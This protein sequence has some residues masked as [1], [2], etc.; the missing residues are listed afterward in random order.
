MTVNQYL[1][2]A[3]IETVWRL[4]AGIIPVSALGGARPL[5]GVRLVL[6]RV[7]KPHP[8]PAGAGAIGNYDVGIGLPAVARNGAGRFAITYSVPG[9]SSPVAVRLYDT[10]RRYVPRRFRLPVPAEATVV[11]AEQAAEQPPWPPIPSRAFRPVLYPGANWGTQ[12]GATA[13]RGRV[14]RADGSAA[15]WARVSA[16]DADHRYPAGWAHGDDRGEFLLVLTPSDAGLFTPGSALAHVTLTI[17]ARPV[18]VTIDSPAQSQA[19]PLWDLE[20]E[21]LPPPGAADTVSDGR[22]PPADFS[23]S[24]TSTLSVVKGAVSC[25]RPPFV[26][27]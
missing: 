13:V 3:Y 16:V 15:R 26:L 20:V 8:V 2:A 23:Q 17:S 12:A 25:P 6:E 7:P 21:T 19:D 9:L 22:T 11:A 1:P 4:A 5:P 18:P 24:V 27:P 10:G 14:L